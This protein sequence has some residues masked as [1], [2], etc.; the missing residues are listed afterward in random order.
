ME[1]LRN[2]AVQST[3]AGEVITPAAC[4][5]RPEFVPLCRFTLIDRYL[6]APTL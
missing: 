4:E 1:L 2:S 6:D 5:H 3:G